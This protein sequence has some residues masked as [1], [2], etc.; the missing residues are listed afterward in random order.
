[1]AELYVK[2]IEAGRK[3]IDDVPEKFKEAVEKRLK[4]DG[5]ITDDK[6]D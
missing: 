5:F 3:K 6:E 4:E 2:L 1:M